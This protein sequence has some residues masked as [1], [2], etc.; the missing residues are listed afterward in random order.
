MATAEELLL[1]NRA[2]T[3]AEGDVVEPEVDKTFYI[4][5]D[6]RMIA[7]PKSVTQ[8]GV[9]SDDD[10]KTITFSVPRYYYDC[11]LSEF[12]IYINYLNAK[13]EGDLF[14][15]FSDMVTVEGD[16]LVFPWVVGRNAVAYKGKAIFNVCMKKIPRDENGDAL[17]DED[18]NVIVEQEF[19][20]TIA[21][22][23][24]LE[25]L[26]TGEEIAE[27]Y[28]DILMQWE[29][30]LF[31][32]GNSI[33]KQIVL[34]GSEVINQVEASGEEQQ[35]QIVL[36]GDEITEVLT[37]LSTEQQRQIVLK[38]DE[39]LDAIEQEKATIVG[40]SNEVK[41][42]GEAQVR[43]IV[44]KGSEVNEALTNLSKTEQSAIENKG[45]EILNNLDEVLPAEFEEYVEANPEK[46]KGPQGEK[47]ETG[48]SV[49]ILDSYETEEALRAAHPT[50]N[51]GDSY[52]VQGDLYVWSET[53]NDWDN[54]GNIQGPK[55]DTGDTGPK[56]DPGEKGDTG[57]TG[58]TGPAGEDGVDGK[59]GISPTVKIGK[60]G[61]VTTITITDA[62]GAHTATINDG[63]DGTGAGDMLTS[64]YDIDGDG[65][66]DSA[67][68]A[69]K[70]GGVEADKYALKTD[71]PEVSEKAS[72]S[73]K[74]GGVAAD[75]YALKTD[76]PQI[77]AVPS[78]LVVVDD[79][80]GNITISLG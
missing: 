64:V 8:L 27:Q 59:D 16:N 58:A 33:Q 57:D 45:T 25:G 76:I 55:G 13:K 52:L 5:L 4:D 30:A 15:V 36:K 54:V 1:A 78:K 62:T 34:K 12:N 40:T 44:E 38:G 51:L 67:D 17:R 75:Q 6:T 21:T 3:V 70:L 56:G 18:D 2:A 50:G 49:T 29:E 43:A 22:L 14:E 63:V 26:E 46:F 39:V 35:R 10:V 23:P 61:K 73:D 69:G 7:I 72:D 42:E 74:L 9:E 68:N 19:N 32:A 66:V 53:L 24:V 65:I 77:P 20:T 28:V 60:V 80:N 37:A 41:A 48:T 79:G 11:D 47:G 71:I 31:G